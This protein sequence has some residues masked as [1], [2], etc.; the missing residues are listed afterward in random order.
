LIRIADK[1]EGGWRTVDEYLS[2]NVATDSEDEKRIRAADS[3]AVKKMKTHKEDTGKQNRKRPAEAV[4]SFTQVGHDDVSA[5]IYNATQ[6][7]RATGAGASAPK[8]SKANDQCYKCGGYGHWA[9]EC[10]KTYNGSKTR[11]WQ[12]TCCVK[13]QTEIFF[14]VDNVEN[15]GTNWHI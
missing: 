14:E 15:L 2:D 10:R 7:F 12:G 3:R 6:P 9:R 5:V 13:R 4:G 11:S 1:S 8:N